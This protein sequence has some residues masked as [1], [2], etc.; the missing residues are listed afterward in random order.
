MPV[1]GEAF[2]LEM[3]SDIDPARGVNGWLCTVRSER[4]DSPQDGQEA[5]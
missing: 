5:A 3:R 2:D 1:E 4:G